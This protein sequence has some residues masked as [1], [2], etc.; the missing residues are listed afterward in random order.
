MSPKE[1]F[2]MSRKRRSFTDE[3]KSEV[4]NLTH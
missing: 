1:V 4:V 2:I 3:Y